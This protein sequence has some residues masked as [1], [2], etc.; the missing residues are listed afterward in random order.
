MSGDLQEPAVAIPRGTFLSIAFTS[1][2]YA[3]FVILTGCTIVTYST[4]N[5]TDFNNDAQYCPPDDC[6]YG[7]INDY[8]TVSLSSGMAHFGFYDIEPFIYTGILAA[9]LSSALG[10]YYILPSIY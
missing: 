8:N 6:K 3:L 1:L 10:I 9:T 2:T 5:G 4:G 7:L